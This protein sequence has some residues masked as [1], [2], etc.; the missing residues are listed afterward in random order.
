M[1]ENIIMPKLGMAMV[2]GTV[3]AWKKREGE[4]VKKGEGIVDISSE[5]IE[6]EVEA[7]ADGVLLKIEVPAGGVVPYGTVLG[8]IG[9]PGELAATPAVVA[10]A[11]AKAESAATLATADGQS[12]ATGTS[13]GASI[14]ATAVLERPRDGVK[15]SPVARKIAEEAGFDFT[16]IAGTGPQGRITKEDVE[17]AIKAAQ[18]TA[19]PPTAAQAAPVAIAVETS[20]RAADRAAE[21]QPERIPVAGMRKVIAERMYQSLQQSAQLTITMQADITEL[22]QLKEKLS[23]EIESRYQL[24]PSVTDW[25]ARAVVLAL[26]KHKQMNSALL[27]D[28]IELYDDIHLGVAVALDKGLVVPVVR[29][30]GKMTLVELSRQ[31]KSVSARAKQNQLAP[32]EMK[33]ST[34]TITNLGSYGVDTFTPVLN[35]PETGILGIGAAKDT[36]V[37][38]GDELQRR[39]LLPLSLT[40][41]HRVLDGAPAAAFLATVRSYLEAPHSLLI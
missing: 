33:G 30:A 27:D 18:E 6:M 20:E 32:E 4:A 21:S 37:F 17:R 26:A 10:E 34:F 8:V 41:D 36:P 2:E 9:Q 35:P 12:A 25:I 13:A 29:H 40:F 16:T 28:R 19:A 39:S 23:P 3:I 7:A 24:K 15:I 14:A 1:A 11:H 31:L 38:V 22:L 5:K